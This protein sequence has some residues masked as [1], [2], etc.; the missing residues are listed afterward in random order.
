[1]MLY[2][3]RELNDLSILQNFTHFDN[4]IRR[5]AAIHYPDYP[6]MA[7]APS[8]ER[9]CDPTRKSAPII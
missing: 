9:L 6:D 5:S 7:S 3:T 1:M 8:A 4:A 2:A